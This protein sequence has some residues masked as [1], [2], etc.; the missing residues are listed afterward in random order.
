MFKKIFKSFEGKLKHS[1]NWSRFGQF[2]YLTIHGF[3]K[4]C[5]W[6]SAYSC[7]FGF[8]FSLVPVLF[9]IVSVLTLLLQAYPGVLVFVRDFA[10]Q[11]KDYYDI[12][13]VIETALNSSKAGITVMN[14]V[15]GVWLVWMARKMFLSIVYA[16][17]RIFKSQSKRKN[18]FNQLIMFVSEFVVIILIVLILILIFIFKKFIGSSIFDPI[19]QFAPKLFSNG[20]NTVVTIV[21]YTILFVIITLVYRFVPG[22]GPKWRLCLFFSLLNSTAFFVLSFF[23]NKFYNTTNYNLIYGTIS[24]VI[25]LMAKVYFF[26]VIFLFGAQMLYVS[27]FFDA[28]LRAEIYLR[29]DSITNNFND[30]MRKVLFINP[31]GI[32]NDK[33][34]KIYQPGEVIYKAGD[35]PEYVYYVC[36]GLIRETKNGEER[37]LAQGAF[38]G[39]IPCILNQ[40]VDA[41]AVAANECKVMVFT[42]AE[43][44]DFLH[45]NPKAAE[46]AL[47]KVSA[48]SA[49]LYSEDD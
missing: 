17:N 24:T 33:N 40:K 10:D 5:M 23:L 39:E 47:S 16:M 9:I 4:N 1:R 30:L 41:T 27:Q 25:I 43:F 19:K 11:I 34:T 8:V 45:K 38:V 6:E 48:Y 20:S 36:S 29:P 15:L 46:K 13:G 32:M 37:F 22:T 12:S 21:I 44:L 28:L 26:F 49:Q 14:V 35:Q 42:E 18:I 2:V 7:S 31:A 3:N